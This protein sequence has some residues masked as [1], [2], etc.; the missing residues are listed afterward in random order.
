MSITR[1]LPDGTIVHEE[2][3]KDPPGANSVVRL[4]K[5]MKMPEYKRNRRWRKRVGRIRDEISSVINQSSIK[6]RSQ[7][8]HPGWIVE[9]SIPESAPVIDDPWE[10][11]PA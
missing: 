2:F 6:R 1:S 7:V 4:E 3:H 9:V 8:R 10:E 11:V 5:L